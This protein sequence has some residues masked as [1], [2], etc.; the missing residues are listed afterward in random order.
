MASSKKTRPANR[1]KF[2]RGQSIPELALALPVLL[3]LLV[4]AIDM[5][6]FAYT[7][8]TLN[9]A[10]RAGAAYGAQSMVTASDIPQIQ[11]VA[12]RDGKDITPISGSPYTC[13]CPDGTSWQCGLTASASTTCKC[14]DGS[15]VKCGDGVCGGG[16][17]IVYVT[18]NTQAQFK[19][20]TKLLPI[21]SQVTLNATAT[22]RVGSP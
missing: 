5:G 19:P 16:T 8:I 10:A 21:P 13:G 9:D 12:Y 3:V 14:A 17:Q 22:R 7:A 15:N 1:H 4:G 6:R 11:C 2:G 20:I 18:V